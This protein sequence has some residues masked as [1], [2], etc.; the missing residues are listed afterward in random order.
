MGAVLVASASVGVA[1]TDG[2]RA[3]VVRLPAF[4]VSSESDS[5]VCYRARYDELSKIMNLIQTVQRP[6]T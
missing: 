4:I 6:G 3:G 1:A 2:R 5:V